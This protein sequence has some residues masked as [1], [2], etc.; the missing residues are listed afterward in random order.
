[1]H[2]RIG[3]FYSVSIIDITALNE[4]DVESKNSHYR[5]ASS[6]RKF[7]PQL[8]THL[9]HDCDGANLTTF[10]SKSVPVFSQANSK[11]SIPGIRSSSSCVCGLALMIKSNVWSVMMGGAV[12]DRAG[13]FRVTSLLKARS[14]DRAMR[15]PGD[16]GGVCIGAR[17]EAEAGLL[18]ATP[19][20][21]LRDGCCVN[22]AFDLEGVVV[23]SGRSSDTLPSSVIRGVIAVGSCNGSPAG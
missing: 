1:M 22:F 7:I 13:N 15:D 5:I 12:A 9:H 2:Q 20:A 8:S 16:S 17:A 3:L 11:L 14:F 21:W 18:L 19:R 6:S 10:L 23:S 4:V